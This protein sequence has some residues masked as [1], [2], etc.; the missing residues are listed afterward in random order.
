MG[1]ELR[2]ADR[3]RLAR[4]GAGALPADV[5]RRRA[6][7]RR[8][9]PQDGYLDPSQLTFALA[10]GAR[11]LR[12][13][14]RAAH[15][16]ARRD[17]R[18]RP[19]PGRRD[20]QGDDPRRRGRERRRHVRPAD[21]ADGRRRGADHP[22]R[23]RVPRDRGVRSAA[24]AA[25]DAARPR[26]ARSTSG[27]R[28][29]ASSWAATSETRRRG[30]STACPDGFE[31]QLLPEDWERFD[32]LLANSVERVPAMETA[33]VR[34]LFNG[35]EAFTPD[36]EFI[37]GESDVPRLLGR[38]RVLRPRPGRRRRHGLAGGRVDRERRAEPR[39][40][41]HGLA[42]VRPPVPQPA[43]TRSRARPRST[44]PTTTSSTPTTSARR[45][46]RCGS[47]RPTTAL[48]ALG[49][50]FG[51][52]SG[53]E[54]PNWFEPNA[55][56]RRRGAAPAGLGGPALV[57]GDP[58]R[59]GRDPRAGGPLRRELVRQDRG[60]GAGR[61]R[62]SSSGCARTTSTSRSARSPTRRC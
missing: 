9:C 40:V 13:R 35:P 54:R 10:D 57:A 39:P 58:R 18:G 45:A 41:A 44:R 36:G 34:K 46:G 32:E 2:P 29:A 4:R 59:G 49:A 52:K 53:W 16:S 48:A 17:R 22:V 56:Q 25:A 5:D 24:R 14:D 6:S 21:R 31:A 19:L 51:E 61:G 38:G 37:L 30:R 43:P 23:A 3:D 20:R 11:R 62:R 26:P 60:V 50:V 8:S 1:E 12:R 42:P 47:R 33:E 28:W 55:A 7:P 15:A 27:P